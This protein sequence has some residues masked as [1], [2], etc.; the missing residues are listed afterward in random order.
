MKYIITESRLHTAM[1]RLFG[2]YINIDK[3]KTHNPIADDSYGEEYEDTNRTIFYVG[4]YYG[5]GELFRYYLCDYF[6]ENAY[7]VL[8][9]CPLL[10]VDNKITYTFNDLFGD[11]WKEPFRQWINETFDL[12]V[13]TIE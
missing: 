10:S 1:I 2:Q 5:E 12:K 13:K 9:K 6:N 3:I 4:D 11:L 8:Q 7:E